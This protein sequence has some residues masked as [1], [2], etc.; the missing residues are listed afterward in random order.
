MQDMVDTLISNN[1]NL[2]DKIRWLDT[3]MNIF[4]HQGH[5]T[6]KGAQQLLAS[7]MDMKIP[8]QIKQYMD[9]ISDHLEKHERDHVSCSRA[10]IRLLIEQD[11]IVAK[12]CTFSKTS[13]ADLEDK[14][15]AK[16]GVFKSIDELQDDKKEQDDDCE[17]Y[18]NQ[19]NAAIGGGLTF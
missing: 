14:Y 15:F 9:N 10:K 2:D 5:D 8:P 13:I 17:D 12:L 16:N 18:Q 11:P 19:V 1:M 4:K 7:Y 3:A 6:K